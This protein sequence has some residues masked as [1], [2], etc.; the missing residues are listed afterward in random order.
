M[1]NDSFT[2]RGLSIE[3]KNAIKIC[4]RKAKKPQGKWL[5]DVIL[6]AAKESVSRRTEVAKPEDVS[7]IIKEMSDRIKAI[8]NKSDKVE[9]LYNLLK[10]PWWKK[11]LN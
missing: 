5:D 11:I 7:D 9:E 10:R 6:K 4:A 1:S 2:V 3:A 8:E